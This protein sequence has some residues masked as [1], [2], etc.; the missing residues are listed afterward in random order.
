MKIVFFAHPLF[1]GSQSMPRFVTML[2]EG[3]EKRGH[4]VEVWR[5]EE[6][7]SKLP[8]KGLKKWLGYIDQYIVF[9]GKVKSKL[10]SKKGD[11]LYVVTDHAL[12]PYVPLIADRPHVIHC[13][14]FLA[15][16]SATGEIKENVTSASGKKY[17]AYIRKGYVQGKNFISVSEK[18]RDDLS[19]FL[20]EQPA[21]S[22][23]VYNGL[24]PFFKPAPLA[25]SREV[26]GKTLGIDVSNGYIL[27]VGGNQWY[28]NRLGVISVYNKWRALYG[29]SIPLVLIGQTPSAAL[30]N[31]YEESDYKNDIHFFSG[32]NDETVRL[33][34]AGASV[35]LFPS[36]AEGFGWPIAEA[37]ASGTLVITTNE[38]P[39]LEVAGDAAFLIERRPSAIPEEEKW[40]EESAAVLQQSLTLTAAEKMEW[41][42]R[43]IDN[44]QR[45]KLEDALNDIE[46]IYSEILTQDPI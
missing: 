34:Y 23:M 17:Q 7:F 33:A 6:L 11:I 45:F 4:E 9:P 39:M 31:K 30:K 25:A 32:L 14:D 20:K 16:R 46:R 24:N 21:R 37:M 27:H 10:S 13:H 43:G 1:L 22:E 3:M 44:I 12:G 26:L 38:T 29:I 2:A 42:Q 15:Q 19:L 28:K 18:T 8:L 41:Q 35:F 5:P 40:A 36:L